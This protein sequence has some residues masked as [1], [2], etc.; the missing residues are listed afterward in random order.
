ME[1]SAPT[2]SPEALLIELGTLKTAMEE[3]I[4]SDNY[5]EDE[6]PPRSPQRRKS[7]SDLK[8]K[9]DCE[10][11]DIK[12]AFLSDSANLTLSA[13][14]NT[15]SVLTA[16][17]DDET[18]LIAEEKYFEKLELYFNGYKTNC[19]GAF[20]YIPKVLEY[21]L[22][23]EQMRKRNKEDLYEP[24]Q[25]CQTLIPSLEQIIK[26]EKNRLNNKSLQKNN[27]IRKERNSFSFMPLK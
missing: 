12:S 17:N 25:K 16:L 13:Y 7:T 4:H 10:L 22:E 2:V 1:L 21:I 5:H 26:Q 15:K 24:S 23:I 6:I 9:F 3:I 19:I 27:S 18:A 11:S 14:R 20:A 8:Q